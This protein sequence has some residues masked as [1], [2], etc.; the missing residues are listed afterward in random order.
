MHPLDN[1]NGD[2]RE[3][4]LSLDRAMKTHVNRGVEPRVNAIESTTTSTLR[5]L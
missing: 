5:D 1:I 4:L 2:I 3:A